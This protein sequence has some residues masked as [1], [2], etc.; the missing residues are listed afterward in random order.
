[1]PDEIKTTAITS[2][3]AA[4]PSAPQGPAWAVMVPAGF[5]GPGDISDQ[6]KRVLK[7]LSGAMGGPKAIV[8]APMPPA[9]FFGVAHTGN[10]A[11]D[12]EHRLLFPTTHPRHPEERF[13]WV[14]GEKRGDGTWVP[15]SEKAEGYADDPT[16]LK[17]GFLKTDEPEDDL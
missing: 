7:R 11:K 4:T 16:R 15:S 1:M 2:P 14:F 10:P 5:A 13:D 12:Q 9:G 3:R 17:F 8:Y 6:H